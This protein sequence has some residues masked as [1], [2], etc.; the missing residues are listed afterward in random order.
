[1][2]SQQIYENIVQDA[3]QIICKW[4]FQRWPK[5]IVK[6]LFASTLLLI[7][8]RCVCVCMYQGSVRGPPR[9][10]GTDAEKPKQVCHLSLSRS[11]YRP[12]LLRQK[13]TPRP[14]NMTFIARLS[15][16]N[17]MHHICGFLRRCI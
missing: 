7:D 14:V 4:L 15:T 1:M 8:R 10:I 9:P 2:I 12:A 5:S 6:D 11:D 17:Y 16:H 3:R 13:M